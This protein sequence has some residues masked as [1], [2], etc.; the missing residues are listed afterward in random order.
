MMSRFTTGLKRYQTNT[1]PTLCSSHRA[2]RC[3]KQSHTVRLNRNPAI[4]EAIITD[5]LTIFPQRDYTVSYIG[6]LTEVALRLLFTAL[7]EQAG[8]CSSNLYILPTSPCQH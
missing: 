7:L 8:H 3:S 6:N 5:F 1:A 4:N 2:D